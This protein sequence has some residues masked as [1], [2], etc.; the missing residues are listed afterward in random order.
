M[1]GLKQRVERKLLIFAQ[2]APPSYVLPFAY[3]VLQ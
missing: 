3:A 2:A 1:E